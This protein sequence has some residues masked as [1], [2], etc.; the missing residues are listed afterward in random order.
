[1]P[2]ETALNYFLWGV[3]AAASIA[4]GLLFLAYWRETR[5]RLLARFAVAFWVLSLNWIWLIAA[6]PPLES[7]HH[8]L[9]PRLVAF[10]I[11]IWA[12]VEKNREP[13]HR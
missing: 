10:A 9:L 8:S 13:R 12:V 3:N 5:E 6:L 7:R 11:I 4:I 2:A 1:M